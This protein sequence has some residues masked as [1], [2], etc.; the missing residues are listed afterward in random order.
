MIYS[1]EI[2]NWQEVGGEDRPIVRLSRETNSGTH[3]YFLESVVTHGEYRQIKPFFQQIPCCSPPLKA[4][5]PKSAITPTPLDMTDWVM[6]P[7]RSKWSRISSPET[8]D[9]YIIPS[10]ERSSD[11]TYL[12]S[13]NLYMYTKINPRA[14]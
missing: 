12:I 9:D 11:N 14:L 7:M 1:G 2:N 5:F 8:P 10:A 13:R 4:S 3:V 6:S